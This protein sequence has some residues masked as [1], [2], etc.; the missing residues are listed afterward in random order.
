MSVTVAKD[1]LTA[2]IRI[3]GW[4]L[5]VV[6]TPLGKQKFQERIARAEAA[7]EEAYCCNMNG[8]TYRLRCAKI[9]GEYSTTGAVC[10]W[11]YN[12]EWRRMKNLE[13]L[14]EMKRMAE[15]SLA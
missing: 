12:G 11:L 15:E 3:P 10:E 6:D 14:E 7:M 1:G 5:M 4:P 9:D 2:T 8:R 13:I